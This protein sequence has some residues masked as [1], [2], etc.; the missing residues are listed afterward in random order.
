MFL[1]VSVPS[2]QFRHAMLLT[3]SS[4]SPD[5]CSFEIVFLHRLGEKW[6]DGHVISEGC[7]L[8]SVADKMFRNNIIFCSKRVFHFN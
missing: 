5:C 8:V 2:Y 1:S 3:A 4:S 6:A 7:D